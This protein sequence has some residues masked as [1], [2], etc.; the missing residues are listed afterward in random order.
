MALSTRRFGEVLMR[1]MSVEIR[2]RGERDGQTDRRRGN[3]NKSVK[4]KSERAKDKN[5]R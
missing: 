2:A 1:T 5:K 4:K 3:E